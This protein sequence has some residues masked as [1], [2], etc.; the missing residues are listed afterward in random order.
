VKRTDKYAIISE[1]LSETMALILFYTSTEKGCLE[2][3]ERGSLTAGD[4]ESLTTVTAL[5]DIER[6]QVGTD[7]AR[8]STRRT[9]RPLS[10]DHPII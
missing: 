6:P 10:G 9:L 1:I 2:V 7:D 8:L 3:A 5:S 4:C